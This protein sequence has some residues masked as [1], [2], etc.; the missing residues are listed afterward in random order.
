M[1]EAS[2]TTLITIGRSRSLSDQFVGEQPSRLDKLPQT[3]P[4]PFKAALQRGDPDLV[5]L[6]PQVYLIANLQAESGSERRG[7]NDA[8]FSFNASARPLFHVGHAY[9]CATIL[10]KWRL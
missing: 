8:T 6:D 1:A 4:R 9:Y 3:L 5:I 2:S 10:R 7:D